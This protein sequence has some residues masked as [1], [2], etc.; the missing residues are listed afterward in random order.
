M[1]AITIWRVAFLYAVSG[2]GTGMY[3]CFKGLCLYIVNFFENVCLIKCVKYF[4][5]INYLPKQQLIA[6]CLLYYY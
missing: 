1:D 2:I 3:V 6:S 4:A 5:L